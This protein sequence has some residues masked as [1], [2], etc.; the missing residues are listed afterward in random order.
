MQQP[1]VL[2]PLW[3]AALLLLV[4]ELLL[5]QRLLVL[6]CGGSVQAQVKHCH[7]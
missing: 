2:H 5:P 4:S 6:G 1:G 3:R 7:H